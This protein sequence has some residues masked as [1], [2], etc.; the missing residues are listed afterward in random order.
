MPERHAYWIDVC[1]SSG[2]C[3]PVQRLGVFLDETDHVTFVDVVAD[4]DGGHHGKIGRP[5]I[6]PAG[7]VTNRHHAPSRDRPRNVDRAFCA[8]VDRG[9]S[10]ILQRHSA[11]PGKPVVGGRGET[12]DDGHGSSRWPLPPVLPR[13]RTSRG[14]DRDE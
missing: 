6:P 3:A 13:C 14:R 7:A 1:P 12:F 10:R 5:D 8:R 11:A 4:G 2:F 9:A